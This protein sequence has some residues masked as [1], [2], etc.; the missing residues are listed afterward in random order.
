M[1]KLRD[2]FRALPG[3]A[4]ISGRTVTVKKHLDNSTVT[5]ATTDGNGLFD[6]PTL[7]YVGPCYYT[8][9]DGTTTRVHSSKSQGQVGSWFPAEGVYAFRALADGVIT[10]PFGANSLLVSAPGSGMTVNVAAGAALGAGQP[11]VWAS[12]QTVTIGAADPTN[13]RVDTVILRFCLPGHAEEGKIDLLAKAGTAA[14]SPTAPALT[15]DAATTFVWEVAL[16]DVRVDAAAGSIAPTKV[17]DRRAVVAPLPGSVGTAQLADGSVTGAKLADGTIGTADLADGS[18]TD[19]KMANQ[20]VNR[21]GDT[22][23]G[24]LVLQGG[25]NKLVG[26]NSAGTQNRFYLSDPDIHLVN[27]TSLVLWSDDL[28]TLKAFIR[29]DDGS[30]S[31]FGPMT[32]AL[33]STTAFALKNAGSLR[34]VNLDT[35]NKVFS[36]RNGAIFRAFS[37]DGV[38]EKFSVDGSGSFLAQGQGTI[39]GGLVAPWVEIGATSGGGGAFADFHAGLNNDYDV[40]L[41]VTN[42]V[43]GQ[44]GKG[45][46]DLQCQTLTQNGVQLARLTDIPAT[47]G[48]AQALNDAFYDGTTA[49]LNVTSTSGAVVSGA[50]TCA[51]TLPNDGKSYDITCWGAFCLSTGTAGQIRAA[52]GWS[53]QAPAAGEYIG[54]SVDGERAPGLG[55]RRTGGPF[56]GAG[57]TYTA[58]LYAKVDS[59]TGHINSGSIHVMAT[60]R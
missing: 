50:P 56:V 20:K 3:A 31:F 52:L 16:A 45:Q 39:N 48:G 8:A 34:L 46:L 25:A 10:G 37:D 36:L 35:I 54:T 21:A 24:S 17:T 38:T 15:Q 49:T 43:A 28:T 57:Q 6:L 42:G 22:M 23:T 2:Y 51:I 30:S 18:V 9:S 11:Y 1:P 53:D 40:R 59:G 32:L 5:T 44:S 13:P 60:P 47:A 33:D 4:G 58:Q 26:K 55:K 7:G 19:A 41:W 29:G 14:A 27:G 12:T